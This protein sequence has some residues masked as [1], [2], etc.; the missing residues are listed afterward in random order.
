MSIEPAAPRVVLAPNLLG[1]CFHDSDQFRV[2]ELWRDGRLQPVVNR[3]LLIRYLRLLSRLGVPPD[4]LRRWTRWF[5]APEKSFYLR[6]LELGDL[7][8]PELCEVLAKNSGA[9]WIV[10]GLPAV[11]GSGNSGAVRWITASGYLGRAAQG[12]PG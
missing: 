10:T 6:D 11:Q 4:L 8:V 2:L 9:V 7:V 1:G 12:D 3:Q 5:T